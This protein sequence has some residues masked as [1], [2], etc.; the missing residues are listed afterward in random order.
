M[1]NILLKTTTLSII[2]SSLMFASG[3]RIPESS[4]RS[5]AL[6]GAYV[7]N[8]SGASATYY[9]PANMTF[10][11][12][13]L[14]TEMNLIYVNLPS[15]EY[16][17]NRSNATNHNF[18]DGTS[19]EG[20]SIIPTIFISSKAYGDKKIRYGFSITVPGGLTRRWDTAYQKAYAQ[21]FALK[22]IEFNP[23]MAYKISNNLSVAVGLRALYSLGAVKSDGTDIG[24][25]ASR[26]MEG[27]V[28]EYGYNIALAYKPTKKLNLSLT[29]RSNIDIKLEGNAKL[30]LSGTKVYDGGTSI[31]VPLP[32]VLA[33][34]SSYDVTNKTTIELEYDKTYW[35]SY[36]KLDFNYND[37]I[38]LALQS[39]FDDP[40]LRNWS[41][42]NA[43]RVGFTHQIN[44]KLTAMLGYSIDGNPIPD[45]SVSFES[46]DHNSNTYSFGFDYNL[47][48]K[49]SIGF[50]Y[51]YSQKNDRSTKNTN[52]D[53]TSYIDG[54]ISNVKAHL[55]SLAYRR[56]F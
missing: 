44:K 22:I 56:T 34:A 55:V 33:L 40:K 21:E 5:I 14:E 3:W 24:K 41:D 50:G 17:D 16:K 52:E 12:D 31:I 4:S 32:A 54:T 51:L 6:S 2:T 42:I 25:P 30:Y 49:S 1:K 48:K 10:N 19:K 36:E 38:P 37:K 15:I 46:S 20:K 29:Y 7:A 28:R 13:I 39:A 18:Y 9:N 27:A 26:D 8:S 47:N 11:K 35:S 53:G 23:T 45:N 43:F